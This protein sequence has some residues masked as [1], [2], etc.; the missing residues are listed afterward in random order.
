[1]ATV[2]TPTS[3]QDIVCL[4]CDRDFSLS[5]LLNLCVCGTPLLVRYDLKKIAATVAP[6]GFAAR[7]PTLW[8]YRELLPLVDDA[9]LVSLGEGLTPLYKGSKPL[10]QTAVLN[11]FCDVGG[12][13]LL[14]RIEIGDR[15]GDFQDAAVRSGAQA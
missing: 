10:I 4:R 15:A 3:A 9:N 2:T 6:E 7:S 13:D 8:R 14:L 5:E 1:M 11:G 12:L